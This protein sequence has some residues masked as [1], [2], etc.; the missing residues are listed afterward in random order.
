[1]R[2]IALIYQQ[3]DADNI[4]EEERAQNEEFANIFQQMNDDGDF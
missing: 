4:T 2:I 1:M 3:M